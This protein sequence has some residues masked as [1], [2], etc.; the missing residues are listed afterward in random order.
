VPVVSESV[1]TPATCI[2]LIGRSARCHRS[3]RFL[4]ENTWR[5]VKTI[6]MQRE[7]HQVAGGADPAPMRAHPGYVHVV[8]IITGTI[9]EHF[10]GSP[11]RQSIAGQLHILNPT[12][13]KN[14]LV[15]KAGVGLPRDPFQDS[16]QNTIAEV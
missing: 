11:L 9:V 5:G 15:Y 8:R 1:D 13:F 4:S 7:A 2:T 6:H 14:G 10:L 12:R 16:T 3:D